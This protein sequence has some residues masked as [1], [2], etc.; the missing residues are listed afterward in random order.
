[1]E[2][3][4]RVTGTLDSEEISAIKCII[5]AQSQCEMMEC[6][7]CA[8]KTDYGCVCDILDGILSRNID[9]KKGVSV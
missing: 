3:N 8:M 4:G 1:M 7:D 9:L 2:I 5:A 6:I